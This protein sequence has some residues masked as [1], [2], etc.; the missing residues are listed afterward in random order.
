LISSVFF[1][2]QPDLG[3]GLGPAGP[4]AQAEKAGMRRCCS[5][6]RDATRGFSAAVTVFRS[7]ARSA[8]ASAIRSR[9]STKSAGGGALARSA[10]RSADNF[11]TARMAASTGG[12]S[13]CCSGVRVITVFSARR[14]ASS[15]AW[16]SAAL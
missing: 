3:C 10:R 14:R 12:Q 7:R 8:S 15:T 4:L 11:A 5:G 13:F 9:M 2:E 16:A 1:L 6:V